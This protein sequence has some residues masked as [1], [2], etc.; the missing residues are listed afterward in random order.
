M[1]DIRNQ[2]GSVARSM[3]AEIDQGLRSYM[4]GVYNYMALGIAATGLMSFFIASNEAL[5]MPIAATP[6]KWVVFAAIIGM[7][8]IAPRV[9]FS[10]SKPMAHAMFWLN[11]ALWGLLLAPWLYSFNQAGAAQD[12]YRAFFITATAFGAMSLYG[13]TTKKNL[14]GW[15]TFLFMAAIGLLIAIILNAVFF[16]SEMMSLIVSC[17]VVVVFSAIT[18]FETQMVRKLYREGDSTNDRSAIFGA[19]ALFGSFA[20]MFIHILNILGIMRD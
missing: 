1:N 6:L 20:T 9:I 4:L 7:G 8:F 12:V 10:G 14:M 13:Y 11:A 19:F 15:G 16:H 18:A 2:Y 3:G 17:A 5:L